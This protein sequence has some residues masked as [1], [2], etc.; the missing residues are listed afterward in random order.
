M[1]PPVA[2]QGFTFTAGIKR[3]GFPRAD[4]SGKWQAAALQSPDDLTVE[5][6]EASGR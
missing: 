3:V 6:V 2:A 5:P 1:L 4:G